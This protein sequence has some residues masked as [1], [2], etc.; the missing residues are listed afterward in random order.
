MRKLLVPAALLACLALMPFAGAQDKKD[1][2]EEPKYANLTYVPTA[3]EVIDK[4]FEMAKVGKD[5]VIFDLGCGD[6]RILYKAAKKY[7]TRGVGLDINGE[8]IKEAMDQ[9]AKY[10]VGT[11]VEVRHGDALKPKDVSDATVVA[12]YMFPEFMNLWLPIAKEKLKP[13]TRIVSHDYS[14]SD[15]TPDQSV[16]VKSATREHKVHLWIVKGDKK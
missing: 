1:N 5:D 6:A 7:G 10:N 4:M 8:R 2:K 11:L 9:A 16:T 15:W 13:G 12:L 3:D 14:F